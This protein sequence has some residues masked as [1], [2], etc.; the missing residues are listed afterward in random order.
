MAPNKLNAA[1]R[2]ISGLL[3]SAAPNKLNA[4]ARVISGLLCSAHISTFRHLST[5]F[6]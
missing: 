6:T 2:V 5:D 3:C 1:A 4:A